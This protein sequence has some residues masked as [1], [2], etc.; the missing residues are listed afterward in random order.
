M[1]HIKQVISALFVAGSALTASVIMPP[2]SAEEASTLSVSIENIAQQQ[3]TMM[4]A[5]FQGEDSYKKD[6]A[7]RSAAAKVE[8]DT[9]TAN[10]TLEPGTY[11]IK[12]YQ[13]VNDDRRMNT[14]PFGMPTEPFGFSNN[15]PVRFGPPSW[16]AAQFEVAAKV[17]TTQ[18]IKIN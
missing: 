11:G 1:S 10:F 12:L 17:T 4:I 8:G 14:N 6:I 3:G 16:S 7:V 15:A 18:T 13:D 2:A 9:V 5:V